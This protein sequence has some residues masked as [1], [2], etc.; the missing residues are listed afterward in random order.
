MIQN[1][2]FTKQKQTQRFQNQT[3]GYQRGNYSTKGRIKQKVET[4]VYTLL[5]MEWKS[6]KDLLYSTGKSTQFSEVTCTRKE[7]KKDWIYVYV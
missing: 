2:L 7:F 1:N 6:N 3:Y 4:D 5:Y